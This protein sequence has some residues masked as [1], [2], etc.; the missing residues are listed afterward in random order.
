VTFA[1]GLVA[2]YSNVTADAREIGSRVA[3]G[4]DV[5]TLLLVGCFTLD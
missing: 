2:A 3:V 1:A 4:V 5:W